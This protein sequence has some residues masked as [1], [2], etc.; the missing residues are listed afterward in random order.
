MKVR[1]VVNTNGNSIPN[2]F[3]IEDG[4]RLVFQ[5][6]TSTIAILEGDGD[7]QIITFGRDW[8]YSRTTMK[9]LNQFLNEFAS[10]LD[11]PC[12]KKVIEKAIKDGKIIYDERLS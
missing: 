11:Y 7:D 10:N 8:D 3:I 2:Q 1:N 5:S 9:Y 6:Y 4:N 12:N